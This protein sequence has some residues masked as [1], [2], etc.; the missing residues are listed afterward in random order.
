M[1]S[2]LI[3]DVTTKKEDYADSL[4]LVDARNYPFTSSVP[5]SAAP[6][7]PRFDWTAD[8]YRSTVSTNGIV[9]GVDATDFV[10]EFSNRGKLTNYVQIFRETPMVS[11]LTQ[12][13]SDMPGAANPLAAATAK[14][15]V[16]LKR[17]MECTFLSSNDAQVD[18]GAVPYKTAGMG[19]LIST[20]GPTV[21]NVPS[22]QRPSSAQVI[23]TATASLDEDTDFQG[24]LKAIFDAVGMVSENYTLLCGSTLRRRVTS[25]TR[26]AVNSGSTNSANRV[27]TFGFEGKAREIFSSTTTFDGDFGSFSVSPS[28]W[29]GWTNNGTAADLTRGY[30]LDMSK[31]S[32]RYNQRPTSKELPDLGGGPRRLVQAI[33][34]LQC[35]SPKGMGKFQP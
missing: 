28:S 13:V 23:T 31:L 33:A 7:N 30:L 25:C 18:T 4:A 1:A 27:R 22:N 9:D 16:E 3:K 35:D 17:K 19:L 29:I 14:G 12:E 21:A 5:K 8:S 32:L 20:A 6:T 15:L 24:I 26:I 2:T 11:T 10:D 34:G